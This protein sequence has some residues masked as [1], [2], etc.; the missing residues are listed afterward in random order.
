M[1]VLVSNFKKHIFYWFQLL[2]SLGYSLN[3]L[4]K[5]WHQVL[6]RIKVKHFWEGCW[7]DRVTLCDKTRQCI[8]YPSRFVICS[9]SHDLK[10]LLFS[11]TSTLLV[12]HLFPLTYLKFLSFLLHRYRVK[13][14]QPPCVA[15][16]LST[17]SFTSQVP[18]EERE[19]RRCACLPPVFK[20]LF[21]KAVSV[22]SN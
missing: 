20:T 22:S 9:F 2:S 6:K 5:N 11:P 12:F 8:I 17:Q 14:L 21:N 13:Q 15:C 18:C 1:G 16:Y 19:I 7:Q 4:M 10:I 3:S